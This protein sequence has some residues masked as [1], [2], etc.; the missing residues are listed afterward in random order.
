M[1]DNS[2]SNDSLTILPQA[3]LYSLAAWLVPG[4]G[5]LLLKRWSRAVLLFICVGTLAVVGYVVRGRAYSSRGEDV[6]GIL[7]FISEVGTGVFYFLAQF[8]E[9]HGSNTARLIGDYGTRFLT[10]AGLLNYL[11]VLD[12]WEIAHRH[13][14]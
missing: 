2:A 3:Y 1:D 5:H 4:L 6:F 9:P 11:C 8:F 14:R 12:V 10:L 7:G 13:K